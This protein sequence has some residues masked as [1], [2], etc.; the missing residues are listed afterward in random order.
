MGEFM[1]GPSDDGNRF[2]D[3]EN[4]TN[5]WRAGQRRI[6]RPVQDLSQIGGFG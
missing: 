3:S 1:G 5:G 6:D 2:D 4:L